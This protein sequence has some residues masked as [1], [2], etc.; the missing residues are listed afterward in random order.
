MNVKGFFVVLS[1]FA[2]TT[3]LLYT[4]GY[5]FN[6]TWLM[7]HYEYVNESNGFQIEMGSLIPLIIGLIASYISE[8]IVMTAE[9]S[10]TS[11]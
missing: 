1:A 3:I 6:I 9:K 7:L 10:P 8:K 4:I 5:T 11:K 2:F